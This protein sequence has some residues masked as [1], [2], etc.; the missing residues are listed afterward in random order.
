MTAQRLVSVT[1]VWLVVACSVVFAL[2]AQAV[3][4]SVFTV[5]PVDARAVTVKAVGDGKADDSTAIQS[6]IDAAFERGGGGIVFL[7]S[8]RYRLARTV[9]VWPGVRLFG[10]GTTRP[11]FALADNTPGFQS[12]LATMIIFA[13]AGPSRTAQ[14]AFPPPDS[15][16][17]SAQISDSNPATFYSAMSN[18]D[19]EIGDRNGAAIAVRFHAAQHAYL[20]HIDF[21]L[22]SGLAGVYQVGNE[23]EDLHFHGGRYGILTEK[24]SSAWPFTL[25]DSS[26]DGQRDAAIREHEAG[27]TLVN[28]RMRNTPVGIEIDRGYGDWLFGRDLRFENVSRAAVVISNEDNAYTQV[29]FENTLASNTPVFAHFRDSGRTVP[30]AGASYRVAD[31]GYGMIVPGLGKTGAYGTVMKASAIN[32]VPAQVAPAIRPLPPMSEWVNV[33][34]LGARGDDATND[35]AVLQGAIAAHRVLYFPAGFYRVT[36]TLRLQP[37]TVLIGLH[38]GLTQ[39]VLPD[40]TPGYQ[41]VGAPKALVEAPQGGDNIVVGLG[42]YTSG[43][44]ARAVALLWKAGATSLVNDVKIQGGHGTDFRDGKRFNPYNTERTGPADPRARWAGQYPGIWVTAGGGGTFANIWSPNTNS[45]SGFRVSDTRTPGRI[46]QLSAEHHVRTEIQLDHV[47]NWE[48]FAPQT[49]EEGGEGLDSIALDIRNSRNIL[50]ANFHGYRVT[51]T[52]KPVRAAI[53]LEN[54]ADI[55]FRNVHVNSESGLGLCDGSGCATFLR[56]SKF[57]YSNAIHDVTSGLEVRER[58]FARLDVAAAPARTPASTVLKPVKLAGDF[59]SASGATVD[60]QGKLYFVDAYFQRI[61]GWSADQGLTLVRDDTHDPVNLAMDK[62]GNLLV[63]SSAGREGTVYSFRPGSPATELA[64]LAPQPLAGLSPAHVALPGNWWV[65]GEFKDRINPTTYEFTTLAEMFAA[66]VRE[67]RTQGYVSPDGSLLL[68]AFRVFAQG[69]DHRGLRFSDSL[70]AYSLVTAAPDEQ[71]YLS[72]DSEGKTYTGRI[73]A[74]GTITALE[75]FANRGG[76]S[77]TKGPDG[78]VYIANGQIFIYRP[79]GKSAGQ[80]DVPERPLQVIFGG[81]DGRTLFILTHHSLYSVR[82]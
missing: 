79:D 63:L 40:E 16:P 42:L 72:N 76:E 32:A 67:P 37:D 4:H 24:P 69:A 29:N 58:E 9:F 17:F 14:P 12:G 7:P 34:D 6:A 45:H 65:N 2:P 36:D 18:V 54:V 44:N 80:I 61:H 26:F 20:S 56:L 66:Y 10:V 15:V 28:V 35:T 38:P 75:V 71:I 51:R 53:Q 30:G 3:S 81:K 23:M 22:G 49:E 68:P 59:W 62:A 27:L 64:V 78:R 31:F 19:F 1:L 52:K 70:D 47:E 5:A 50:I 13:G 77:V 21:E 33:R 25:L 74:S 11:V 82:P 48:L 46:Y 41:G 39:I 8:G 57:P 73:S 55:R 60:A 43:I